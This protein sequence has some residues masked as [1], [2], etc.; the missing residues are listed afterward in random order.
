MTKKKDESAKAIAKPTRAPRKKPA[1]EGEVILKKPSALLRDNAE[2]FPTLE[3]Q[4]IDITVDAEALDKAIERNTGSLISLDPTLSEITYDF[5]KNRGLVRSSGVL[6]RVQRKVMNILIWNALP[7]IDTKQMHKIRISDILSLMKGD[8]AV[9]GSNRNHLVEVL[10]ELKNIEISLHYDSQGRENDITQTGILSDFQYRG[11]EGLVIYGFSKITN[12]LLADASYAAQIDVRLQAEIK[13]R[14]TLS[15][16]EIALG[17]QADGA[18]PMWP[19]EIWRRDLGVLENTTYSEYRYFKSKV[20]NPAVEEV[21]RVAKIRLTQESIA[22]R[23]TRRVEAFRFVIEKLSSNEMGALSAVEMR[24]NPAF[25]DLIFI[26]V[27]KPLAAEAVIRDPLHASEVAAEAKAQFEA[28]TVKNPGAWAAKML[29]EYIQ[30]KSGL[31]R[32]QEKKALLAQRSAKRS[33]RKQEIVA[34]IQLERKR[35]NKRLIDEHLNGL[36]ETELI[37]T[38][39]AATMKSYGLPTE[40]NNLA[41]AIQAG[42]QPDGGFDKTELDKIIK[43]IYFRSYILGI[44]DPGSAKCDQHVRD[45]YGEEAY[46]RSK[47]I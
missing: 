4:N 31:Q 6:R 15:L 30:V 32:E 2:M 37:N 40:K 35:F 44:V 3:R 39:R 38:A 29:R 27:S 16:L 23:T 18:T 13:S 24:N 5:R 43:N 26:G 34:D 22:D 25:K 33:L 14:Y 21:F 42:L 1:L 12:A 9:G 20:L 28:G 19:V 17:Y 7:E 8:E 10:R 45:K 11:S 41:A 47:M 36:S 46:S